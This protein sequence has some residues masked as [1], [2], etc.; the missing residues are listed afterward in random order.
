MKK[1]SRREALTAMTALMAAAALPAGAALAEEEKINVTFIIY[2][3]A[4]DPFWNPVI[5]GAQEAAKDRKARMVEIEVRHHPPN[6]FA[7]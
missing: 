7:V 2:T 6:L 3:A 4:G 1:T 5:H